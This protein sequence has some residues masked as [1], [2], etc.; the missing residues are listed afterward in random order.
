MTSHTGGWAPRRPLSRTV[1][2]RSSHR[3][4]KRR[5]TMALRRQASQ[6][7]LIQFAI[8]LSV[9]FEQIGR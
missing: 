1:D 6:Y 2:R 3:L 9:C 8:R 4:P 7:R 5:E